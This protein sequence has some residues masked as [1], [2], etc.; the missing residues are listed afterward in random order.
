[1]AVNAVAAHLEIVKIRMNK[2]RGGHFVAA[3]VF[4]KPRNGFFYIII[5][6]FESTKKMNY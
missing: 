3:L 6:K 2:I 1:M 4:K 5:K